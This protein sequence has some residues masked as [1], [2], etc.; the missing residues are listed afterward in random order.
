MTQRLKNW[1][2]YAALTKEQR[3]LKAGF[4]KSYS[5]VSQYVKTSDKKAGNCH[6]LPIIKARVLIFMLPEAEFG[7]ISNLTEVQFI[8]VAVSVTPFISITH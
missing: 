1:V 7:G 4:I 6:F 5:V 3:I 2:I 8:A